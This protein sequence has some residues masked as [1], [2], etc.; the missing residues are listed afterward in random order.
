LAK[1]GSFRTPDPSPNGK[2]SLLT[3][4]KAG[5]GEDLTAANGDSFEFR[6]Y[7]I[8]HVL[9]ESHATR[10]VLAFRQFTQHYIVIKYFKKWLLADSASAGYLSDLLEHLKKQANTLQLN[11]QSPEYNGQLKIEGI[12]DTNAFIFLITDYKSLADLRIQLRRLKRFREGQM[13]VLIK[14]VVEAM[15]SLHLSQKLILDLTPENILIDY[16]GRP[17]INLYSSNKMNMFYRKYDRL[18]CNLDY[19]APEL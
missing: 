16:A 10:T 12:Y 2:K 15:T 19:A 8:L 13:Q 1:V 14:P 11:S 9:A 3:A 4:G 6:D 17:Y 5:T 7:K 18:Y